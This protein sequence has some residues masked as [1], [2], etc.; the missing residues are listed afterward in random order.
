MRDVE[1]M[2]ALIDALRPWHAR[3][4]LVGG[5][6]HRLHRLHPS[7]KVPSYQPVVT[8]DADVALDPRMPLHGNIAEALVNAGFTK[9]LSGEHRPPVSHFQLGEDDAGFYAEFLSP[10]RGNGLKGDGTEDATGT[11]GGITT[12]K[13]KHL[14]VLLM[15][16]W[17]LELV[18]SDELP[19]SEP[20][21]VQVANPVSFIAQKLL[22]HRLRKPDKRSQD[23]LYIHDT[24]ELF[25]AHLPAMNR[26][27]QDQT[28]PSLLPGDHKEVLKLARALFST[29]TDTIREASRKTSADRTLQPEELRQRAEV[30]L[31]ELFRTESDRP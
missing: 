27:W 24:L 29:V 12:Q 9:Q 16:P 26:I 6:A 10:L 19:I 21:R 28:G 18:P 15:A 7:A 1:A 30:G 3:V 17:S 4:V 13:L 23:L 11:A 2:A 31:G 8:R 5:W 14:D 25:G 20:A 22:I